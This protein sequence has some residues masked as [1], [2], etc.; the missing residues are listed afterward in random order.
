MA[1]RNSN[2]GNGMDAEKNTD[3]E[4]AETETEY[5]DE[6]EEFEATVDIDALWNKVDRGLIKLSGGNTERARRGY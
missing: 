5:A 6:R 1:T 3:T 2:G 4:Y